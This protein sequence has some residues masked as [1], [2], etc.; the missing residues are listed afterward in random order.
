[1]ASRLL[2]SRLFASQ[3]RF[4][5]GSPTNVFTQRFGTAPSVYQPYRLLNTSRWILSAKKHATETGS[6][7]AQHQR[8]ARKRLVLPSTREFLSVTMRKQLSR[9]QDRASASRIRYQ[10]NTQ[11]MRDRASSWFQ[12]MRF[13]SQRFRG[14]LHL[15]RQ[16]FK[17]LQER[18]K[19]NSTK[20]AHGIMGLWK[21]YG[22]YGVGTYVAVYLGTLAGLYGAVSQGLFTKEH[23]AQ[24][25]ERFHLEGHIPMS[26]LEGVDSA[27]GRL[28]LAW[29]G[30][31]IVEPVRAVV[32]IGLTPFVARVLRGR[33]GGRLASAVASRFTR[34]KGTSSASSSSPSSPTSVSAEV[35]RKAAGAPAHGKETTPPSP[36]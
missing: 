29:I 1:M 17:D 16:R 20:A 13:N 34:R 32:A 4:L 23:A 7:I 21:K 26:K 31:K 25:V 10:M 12:R 9:L 18:F 11:L 19:K 8:A 6:K 33:G 2:S 28:L 3:V 30:T 24:L 14:A 27:W 36:S 22:W 35:S 5:P 15:R